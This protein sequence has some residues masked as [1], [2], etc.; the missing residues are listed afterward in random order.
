[1]MQVTVLGKVA[2]MGMHVQVPGNVRKDP[3]I[4]ATACFQLQD[5]LRSLKINKHG[6]FFAAFATA[7]NHCRP[8]AIMGIALADVSYF[9]HGDLVPPQTSRV[10]ELQE[11]RPV[12][13]LE[14]PIP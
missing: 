4:V 9:E 5:T 14:L 2:P 8:T 3:L 6:A 7:H 11:I 12:V 10:Q 1:M 13:R